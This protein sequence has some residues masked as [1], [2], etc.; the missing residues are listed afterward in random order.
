MNKPTA[1]N[2]QDTSATG[3]TGAETTSS[4]NGDNFKAGET[5]WVSSRQCKKYGG[6]TEK[7]IGEIRK[8]IDDEFNDNVRRL[9]LSKH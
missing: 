9:M 5:Q 3:A 4:N 2:I 1:N 7:T 8:A 6:M